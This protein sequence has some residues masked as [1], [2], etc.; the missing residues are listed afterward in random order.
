M[1]LVDLPGTFTRLNP[2]L[3]PGC[4]LRAFVAE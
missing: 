2:E 1:K 4:Y 3:W